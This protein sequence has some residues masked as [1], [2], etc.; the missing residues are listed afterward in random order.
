MNAP[1]P[2]PGD[3]APDTADAEF[4]RAC[5]ERR[6]LVFRCGE[7]GRAVWP[8]GG[9]PGHGMAPMAW[10]PASGLGRLRTWTVVHQ[11]YATSFDDPPP[12]VAL[13]ELDEGPLV[14]AAVVGAGLLEVGMRVQVDFQ[15]AAPEVVIPVFRPVRGPG[16]TL[17]A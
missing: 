4:W 10:E 15:E 6:F 14:H 3:V 16:D 17:G 11:R 12:N 7:C 9:C 5:R 8:A 13:V 1:R 2:Y